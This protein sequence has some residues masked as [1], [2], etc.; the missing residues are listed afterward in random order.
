MEVIKKE[1][2]KYGGLRRTVPHTHAFMF[3]YSQKELIEIMRGNV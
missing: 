1:I 3:T 2:E